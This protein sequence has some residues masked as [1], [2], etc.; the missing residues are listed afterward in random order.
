MRPLLA[1]I[2]PGYFSAATR[3]GNVSTPLVERSKH[4][5]TLSS[6][7]QSNTSRGNKVGLPKSHKP[8]PLE[9]RNDSKERVPA[10]DIRV[11]MTVGSSSTRGH[12]RSTSNTST[13][14]MTGR[15]RLDTGLEGRMNP[16][17]MSPVTALSPPLPVHLSTISPLAPS[18]FIRTPIHVVSNTK[19]QS[20][21]RQLSGSTKPLPI[22]PFPVSQA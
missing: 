16:L 3:Y 12:S 21:V 8:I 6:S 7:A 2:M 17:R 11:P 1:L 9:L 15:K 10:V 14:S 4:L 18:S 20:H 5:R 19:S 22:T 13:S